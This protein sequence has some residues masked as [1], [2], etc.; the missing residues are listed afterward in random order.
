MPVACPTQSVGILVERSGFTGLRDSADRH[1]VIGQLIGASP[2]NRHHRIDVPVGG[3]LGINVL[4]DFYVDLF[5]VLIVAPE[6]GGGTRYRVSGIGA[7]SAAHPP[8]LRL[9][10]TIAATEIARMGHSHKHFLN[11][12]GRIKT[13]PESIP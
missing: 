2:R 11:I 9:V 10:Q 8:E 3:I 5:A 13:W 4:I 1:E 12:S 6:T 7:R